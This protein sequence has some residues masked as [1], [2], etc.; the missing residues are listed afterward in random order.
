MSEIGFVKDIQQITIQCLLYALCQAL[1][2]QQGET[3]I[4]NS[5]WGCFDFGHP[6]AGPHLSQISNMWHPEQ[7]ST[8]K[9]LQ[10]LGSRVLVAGK[11]SPAPAGSPW[12]CAQGERSA[13]SMCCTKS[14]QERVQTGWKGGS[15]SGPLGL[16]SANF[17]NHLTKCQ[18]P[19]PQIFLQRGGPLKAFRMPWGR[20]I[21]SM[22][23]TLPPGWTMEISLQPL[24]WDENISVGSWWV[25]KRVKKATGDVIRWPSWPF[26]HVTPVSM[27]IMWQKGFCRC[28]AT[29]QLTLR[30][31]ILVGLITWVLKKQVFSL[32]GGKG[33]SD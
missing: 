1:S 33:E 12:A 22:Q 4:G 32:A 26:S 17:I 16:V 21:S 11:T 5:V 20:F 24:K 8:L 13:F 28:K 30:Q 19:H 27:Y 18:A 3:Q 7:L 29:N 25:Y 14:H 9:S 15:F 10:P 31:I 2:L 6:W 23:C